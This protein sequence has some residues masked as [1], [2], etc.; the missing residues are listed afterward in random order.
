MLI[1]ANIVSLPGLLKGMSGMSFA[2]RGRNFQFARYRR[3]TQM[4]AMEGLRRRVF[5]A[6]AMRTKCEMALSTGRMVKLSARGEVELSR[7]RLMFKYGAVI[8]AVVFRSKVVLF[9]KAVGRFILLL[10]EE[11]VMSLEDW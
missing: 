11:T 4:E 1:A 9:V 3:E 7:G 2:L 6:S 5:V 10:S 8:G